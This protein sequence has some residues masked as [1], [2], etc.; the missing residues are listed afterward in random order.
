VT[1]AVDTWR[2]LTPRPN[3]AAERLEQGLPATITDTCALS[4]LAA[5]VSVRGAEKT[6]KRR[7][8]A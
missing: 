3:V 7:V 1:S 6:R 2:G 5:L 4:R 8:K